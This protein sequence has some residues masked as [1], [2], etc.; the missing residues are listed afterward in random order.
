MRCATCDAEIE[1]KILGGLC[2]VCL[3]D[4]ALPQ[5]SDDGA[6]VFRYDLI[7]E[8]AR[9]GMGVVYRAVQQGSQR[10]VAVKMI[11][12]EQAATPGMMERFRAEAE[13]VASLD[14]PHILPIYEIGESEGRPFYSMK[15]A[16]GGTL[17]GCATDFSQPRAA[18]R[19]MATIA[20]A[21]EHAHQR[22]ILHRDLKPGNVLL[23]GPDRTPYVSDFG[24]A[25]WIGR[26]SRL[27]LA[28]SALG[29]PHYIAPEQAA[30]S[31]SKL[32]PAADVYSLGAILYELLIAQPPFVADTPLETLRLSRETEPPSLRSLKSTV[33]RDLEV[34]CLKCLAKDPSARYHSAAALAA[35][36]E[37]WLE[38]Q[39]ILAR[40]ANAAERAWRWTKR[41]RAVATLSAVAAIALLIM[42]LVL[43][44]QR[45]PAPDPGGSQAPAKSIALLPFENLS[46]DPDNAYF[47]QGVEEE[48]LGRL[49][50]IADLKV[51][52]RRSTQGFKS[53]PQ[54][55]SEIGRELGVANILEGS[56]Q[57]EG[58]RVRVQVQLINAANGAHLWAESYDHKFTDV[59]RVESKVAQAVAQR[60]QARLTGSEAQA[61]ALRPTESAA[62]HQSYLKGRYFW[63]KT[64]ADD[65]RKAIAYFTESTRDDPNYAPAYAGLADAYLLLP[66]IT[67]GTPNECYPKAKEAAAKAL[68]LDDSL[69][70]AHVAYAEAIRV[71]DFDQ[72][73]ADAE[74][75]RGLALN[76]NYAYGHWRRAW[77]LGSL[78]RSNEAFAEMRRAV[79][80]DPLS[81]IIN[82]DLGYLY[83]VAGR[84][85]EAIEQLHRTL[86][87]DPNFYYARGNLGEA[88]E[89]KGSYEA[90]LAEYLKVRGLNDDPFGLAEIAHVYAALGNKSEALKALNEMTEVAKGRY[91]EAYA[92]ALVYA[93]LG[94][95]DEAFRWLE[96]S[97]KDR[98]GADLAFIRIDPFLAPLR[99]DPRFEA[100]ADKI[101]PRALAMS[102]APAEKSIA[103]LPFASPG[104]EQNASF[105]LG[106]QDEVLTHLAKIADLKVIS[107]TSVMSYT[108]GVP[109]NVREIGK[110][111]G[112]AHVLEGSVQRSGNRVR[113]NVQLIDARTDSHLWAQTYDRDLADVF[114]IQT[115]IA[116]TI[117]EQLQAKLSATEKAAIE[118][119]PT[120]DLAAFD[121][122][123]RAKTLLT[124]I[125]T[126]DIGKNNLL[127]AVEL[128]EQAVGRDPAFVQGYCQ[129]ASA[130]DHL[131]SLFDHTPARL[132]LAE[133]AIQRA[134]QLAPDAAELHLALAQ[135]FYQG[136]EDFDRARAEVALAQ[137]T[138]PNSPL[139]FSWDAFIDRRQGRWSESIRKFQRSVELDPRNRDTHMQ[140]AITY[141][142]TRHY[143]ESSQGLD[144]I[145]A[146]APKDQA[147]RVMKAGND[148]LA[149]ADTIPLHSAVDSILK[150]YPG[151]ARLLADSS[152]YVALCER[153][154]PGARRAI[155]ALAGGPIRWNRVLL[156]HDFLEGLL[157]RVSGDAAAA[158][159]AFTAARTEQEKVVAEQPDYG[160]AVCALGLI[161]AGLG[162]KEDALREGRRA[163]ELLPVT[164]DSVNGALMIKL[165]ALLCAW[166][167]EK[168]L[169]FEHLTKAAQL[170]GHLHYGELQLHPIWDP[171]RGDARFDKIVAELG[172]T[173]TSPA[174]AAPEKS[175]AVLPFLDLSPAK[176][177]EYFCDGISEQI[178]D[179]LAQ[180]QGLQVAARTS[181]FSFKGT[182][183]GVK[184]IAAKLG[185][186]NLLEGSLRRDG[187]RIRVTVQLIKAS[188]GFH[189]WS[190]T[191][192]RELQ[193]V[194][195]LQDE[196]TK[197]VT[198][199][200]KLKL[201]DARPARTE[202][203]EA[204]ELYLQGVFFSNKSTEEGLRKSLEFFHR[205]LEKDPNSARTYAGIAKAWNWLGDAYVEPLEAFPQMKAAALKAVELDEHVAEGHIW[206]GN[207]K[208]I[209]DWDVPGCWAE[210][211]RALELDPNSSSA[212]SIRT[213]GQLCAGNKKA[214]LADIEASVRLDPLSP[215]VSN[216]AA[217][218][219]LCAGEVDEAIAEAKR[220]MQLDPNYIYESPVLG[221]AYFEKGLYPEAIAI[222]ERAQQITGAPQPGLAT[223]YA[224][225]GRQAEARQILEALKKLA[226]TK[227]I[228][229]EEIAAIYVALG[230]RD[231]AFNW[232]ER[233]YAEH[234]GAFHAVAIRPDFRELHSDPRFH[235]IIRRI[236]L[237]PS[238]LFDHV[239]R[240]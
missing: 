7:E 87:I 135:H 11:L 176:D 196:I 216:F 40:P 180:I 41:N 26:E 201:I 88:L 6:N 34:I 15:F 107:R 45:F 94:Q 145:L 80:L 225:I 96:K 206:L 30:G 90:A 38:G 221:D 59:F 169:A 152:L 39:T 100:L 60:L 159:A 85:D 148:L 154:F 222:F 19:L 147:S 82:T 111:L 37:R 75:Q 195:A 161:D 18:A 17:R 49:G 128:L 220:L 204:Y 27:T 173:T 200:L 164:K 103:V 174:P 157:A 172:P 2:P 137:K 212:H 155:A 211:D 4:A 61:I 179:S 117:S 43:R 141:Q 84:Y 116:R 144:R 51:I 177:Q 167:G 47:V 150:E 228:P 198:S 231:E 224:R 129:M 209:L 22:G 166:V 219:Y 74:F 115:E 71:Y 78:G 203:T 86:E 23:D 191:Y 53:A 62:A 194:F 208:R 110:Q 5:D 91:V 239:P 13:A 12:A 184:E 65:L 109:R 114:A 112:V 118:T 168:D 232:L 122:Y 217:V 36:L 121:L 126:S 104:D 56:V 193:G 142:H 98:A 113:V 24:L 106:M 33:P 89:F 210:I 233:G 102:A 66:F 63:N 192:E 207:A 76:P 57:R 21:V 236:G 138:L 178:L 54:N 31:S 223:T 199:A 190:Q 108:S 123:S 16:N 202:N 32:T 153:D 83:I 70:E 238:L 125:D 139:C 186:R 97:Y 213:L 1:A 44:T 132:A 95:K 35:D 101:V 218:A 229:A 99:G 240:S 160:P 77:L 9:G 162:R 133:A 10:Q 28:Q 93:A 72:V 187:N 143:L 149:R 205:S 48:I 8:I 119:P 73:R 237:D 165:F 92:F 29:T 50:K 183:L 140:L 175:I 188:D 163:M 235:D 120:R 181:S 58:D 81:L 52:S 130:H 68:E 124:G 55:L 20:R 230:E 182:N 234:G 134:A 67:G 105:V 42:A 25:R 197:A 69:A 227:H 151:A 146:V 226:T 131:Y 170:P 156:S 189:L 214:A 136:R 215:I 79:E 14:H 185:V 158:Q 171:L 64:T 127:Q 3:F 46:R